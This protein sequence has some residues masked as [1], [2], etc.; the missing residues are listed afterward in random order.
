MTSEDNMSFDDRFVKHL[1]KL[2]YMPPNI[3]YDPSVIDMFGVLS[4]TDVRQPDRKLWYMY[5][6]KQNEVDETLDRIFKKYGKKNMREIFRKRVF[7]GFG[8]RERLKTHFANKKLYVKEKLIE[9]PRNSSFNDDK[10]IKNVT[11]VYNKE[12]RLIFE[13]VCRKHLGYPYMYCESAWITNY[14]LYIKFL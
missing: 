1:Q 10:V 12:R 11:E 3:E 13:Y 6:C 7:S 5:Y 9:A 4:L 14:I 8:L 2:F